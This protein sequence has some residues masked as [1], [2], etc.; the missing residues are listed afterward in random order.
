MDASEKL[1][2]ES[3]YFVAFLTVFLT[4]FLVVLTAFFSALPSSLAIFARRDLRREAVF[5]FKRPFLTALSYS[6]WIFFMF[7]AVGLALKFLRAV[8]IAF[9]DFLV[10]GSALGGLASGLLC[11]LD[12]RHVK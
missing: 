4:V 1:F 10:F 11:R 3:G 8:L 5:F 7:S 6:L 9:F 12:N 2:V